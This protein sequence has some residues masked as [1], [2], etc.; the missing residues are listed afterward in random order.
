MKVLVTGAEGQLGHDVSRELSLRGVVCAAVGR[1]ALDI[2]DRMSVERCFKKE[3]PDAVIHCAAYTCVD[4][5]ETERER[6]EAVNVAGTSNIA[7]ACEQYGAKLL[8][9]SSDYVYGSNG[10][11]GDSPLE[12]DSPKAPVNFY[13]YTKLEGEKAAALCSRLF[14]VRISWAFGLNG[15]N[16]VKTMLRLAASNDSIKVVSDQKGSPTYT[17][18]LSVLLCDMIET[19]KY[20]I[21]NAS[22]EGVCTWEEFAREIFHLSDRSIKIIP[23]TT[24]EYAAPAPRQKNSVMSKKSLDDAGFKRLPPWR[25][26]LKRFIQDELSEKTV[27]TV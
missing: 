13:G 3:K 12:T 23:V 16:F 4:K 15:C 17:K 10:V 25:D 9:I 27:Q 22:N 19:D 11:N 1:A 2:T 20:G 14:I 8:Y 21:Y 7:R 6:C 5:A 24:E 26:A 18:D